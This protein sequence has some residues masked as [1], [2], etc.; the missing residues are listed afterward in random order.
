VA[1][2]FELVVNYGRD[3]LRA[4]QACALVSAE[5]PFSIGE[6]TVPLHPPLLNEVVSEDGERYLEL[7]VLPVAVG[8]NVAMDRDAPRLPLSPEELTEL[9]LQLYRLLTRF[10]GYLAA[11]VGWDPEPLVDVAELRGEW[12]DEVARGELPGLVLAD[13]ILG[14]FPASVGFEEFEAGFSWIPYRGEPG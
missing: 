4:Q 7:S 2:A 8:C 6:H 5:P 10:T 9:G 14:T 11:K 3:R 12:L 13:E 1:L